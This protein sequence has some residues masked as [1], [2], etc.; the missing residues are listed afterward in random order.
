[1]NIYDNRFGIHEAPHVQDFKCI[2]KNGELS[3]H[4]GLVCQ[5]PD[6]IKLITSLLKVTWLTPTTAIHSFRIHS[7]STIPLDGI[8]KDDPATIFRSGC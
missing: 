5:L 6:D 4:Y 7:G 2:L 3:L 8:I 1:M